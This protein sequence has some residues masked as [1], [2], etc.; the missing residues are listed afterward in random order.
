LL[1][2]VYAELGIVAASHK[3]AKRC[4]ELTEDHMELMQDFDIA[5]AHEA[6]ARAN[7]LTGNVQEAMMYMRKTEVSGQAILM[8]KIEKSFWQI[9]MVAIGMDYAN[10]NPI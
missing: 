5:Y 2:R 3:H 1:S 9:L 10:Q 8:M 6:L 7:A 4:L